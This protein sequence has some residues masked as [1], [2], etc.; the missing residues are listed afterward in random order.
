MPSNMKTR[1]P[2]T[3]AITRVVMFAQ[4]GCLSCDLMRVFLEAHEVVF[5]ERDIAADSEA[6]R[7][8]TDQHGSGET[9]TL[10]FISGEMQEVVIG[11]N[12]TRLDLLLNRVSSSDSVAES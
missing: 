2:K 12:P 11:F 5:E 8:M 10:V 7:V 9:P 1:E 6:R 3:L 4:P